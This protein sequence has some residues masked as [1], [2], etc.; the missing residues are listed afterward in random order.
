MSATPKTFLLEPCGQGGPKLPGT[1]ITVTRSCL[2]LF[3]L[4]LPGGQAHTTGQRSSFMLLDGSSASECEGLLCGGG[5]RGEYELKSSLCQEK[6]M[7][8]KASCP[9]ESHFMWL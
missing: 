9:S 2:G 1:W 8:V 5:H 6:E 3:C 7:C 4:S